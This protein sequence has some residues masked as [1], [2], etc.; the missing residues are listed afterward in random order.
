[1]AQVR[2]CT[3][4]LPLLYMCAYTGGIDV[5]SDSIIIMCFACASVL[6]LYVTTSTQQPPFYN[7]FTGQPALASTSS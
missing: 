3:E 4:C 2:F 5:F 7:Q 6:F 1:M